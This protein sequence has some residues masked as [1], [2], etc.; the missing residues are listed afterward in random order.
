LLGFAYFWAKIKEMDYTTYRQLFD[1]ILNQPNPPAPYDDAMY[2]NYTKL[3][4]SRMNR[5]DKQLVLDDLL[6]SGLKQIAAPQQWIIIT[7]PWCG[8]AAHIVPFL[9]QMAEQ[10]QLITYDLQLRDSEPFLIEH[11]LTHGTRSI[12]KLIV[13]D[14]NGNDIFGWGP[15]PHGAQELM[16]RMR[17]DNADFETIKIALQNWYNQDKGVS[18]C[19]ELMVYF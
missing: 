8:D 3:N 12:P 11:Y 5:W 4:R 2:F 1:E 7:E 17:A 16:D 6:V 18:L 9:I 15:R 19:K 13:R 14:T 10:N